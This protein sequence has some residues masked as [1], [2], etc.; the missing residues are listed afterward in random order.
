MP[1]GEDIVD[2]SDRFNAYYQAALDKG[3][4]PLVLFLFIIVIVGLFV[5]GLWIWTQYRY[6]IRSLERGLLPDGTTMIGSQVSAQAAAAD[7]SQMRQEFITETLAPM[8]SLFVDNT[9]AIR[10]LASAIKTRDETV[11]REESEHKKSHDYFVQKT[12]HFSKDLNKITDI[13]TKNSDTF[14]TMLT[15]TENLLKMGVMLFDTDYKLSGWNTISQ[16]I[17]GKKGEE[18]KIYI[19]K[20]LAELGVFH[21]KCLGSNVG[22]TG[23]LQMAHK[24]MSSKI[25]ILELSFSE[26]EKGEWNWYFAL[27]LPFP[28]SVLLILMDVGD[29]TRTFLPEVSDLRSKAMLKAAES[30]KTVQET[31]KKLD[32]TAKALSN[33]SKEDSKIAIKPGT[34]KVKIKVTKKQKSNGTD[35]EKKVEVK[36]DETEKR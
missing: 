17:V 26:V 14:S 31:T 22:L 21:T 27:V 34:D 16:K 1:D 23:F 36:D 28:K 5:L 9:A 32:R 30:L 20:S 19:G 12:H 29:M 24:E 8:M 11:D 13:V 4:D 7:L 10:E 6:K 3:A 2:A 25:D 15:G 33:L 18:S 35:T